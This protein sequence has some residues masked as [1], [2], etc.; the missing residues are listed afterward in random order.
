M[1]GKRTFAEKAMNDGCNKSTRERIWHTFHAC[2]ISVILFLIHTIAMVV[3]ALNAPLLAGPKADADSLIWCIWVVADF[4]LGLLALLIACEAPTNFLATSCM[5]V[6]GGFQWAIW[7]MCIQLC[8]V[9]F[10]HRHLRGKSQFSLRELLIV[11]T[12]I[13]MIA[14]LVRIISSW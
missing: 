6:I 13:G 12:V 1:K 8:V 5:L 11:T 3:F 10:N 7:G 4:P 2:R 9:L 14:G